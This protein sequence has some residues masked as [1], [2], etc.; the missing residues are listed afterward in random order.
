[1]HYDLSGEYGIGF[2]SSGMRFLFDL[3]DYDKIKDN[4]WCISNGYLH[5]YRDG[6]EVKMHRLVTGCPIGMV[7]D[8]INLNKLDNRKRNLR[9]CAVNQNNANK[10]YMSNNRSGK[11]GVYWRKSR[12]KW[13]AQIKVNETVKHIGCF[14]RYDEAVKARIEAEKHYFGEYACIV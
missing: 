8:H 4:S 1:M 5:G 3:D 12:K 7:V 11:L 14:D 2:T 9:I 10:N 13:I 6:K